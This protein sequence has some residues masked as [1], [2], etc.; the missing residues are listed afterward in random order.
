ML[1]K[2]SVTTRLD[3]GLS[4]TEFS[5]ML[6]QATD[7]EHLHR[8]MGVEL[9]MGGA[10]QWGNITAGPR[11]DPAAGRAGE[12]DADARRGRAGP[13]ASPTSSCSR[14]PAR[15]SARP[16]A[17]TSVWLD[18][19]ADLAVRVLPVLAQRRR[20]RRRDVPALVHALARE[21]DRGARRA[22][23]RARPEARERPAS[24]GPGRD[25]A[26]PRRRPPRPT[27]AG[28]PKRCS[29]EPVTVDPSI[30][31]G[32]P[33]GGR[34]VRP[35]TRRCSRPATATL[36]RRRRHVR[37]EGRGPAADLVRAA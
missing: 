16:R 12:G 20:P 31:A 25:R 19:D 22:T 8:T 3:R 30:L 36:A 21:R 13:R 5:Y 35:S 32:A 28:C 15:S 27:R 4:F 23:P 17:A 29:R 1:A 2:D 6:I 26:D 14:R 24:A 18:A 34:R 7:Y 33:R 37:V 11:A 9:Q 10:D